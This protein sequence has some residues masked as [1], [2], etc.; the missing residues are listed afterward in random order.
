MAYT[1]K[2]YAVALSPLCMEQRGKP[3]YWKESKE[4][5]R[6][7]P[8]LCVYDGV[9]CVGVL[10]SLYTSF[11]LKFNFLNVAVLHN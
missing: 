5:L 8:S 3:D 9:G 1:D 10:A 6:K 7:F 2:L 11:N 4:K